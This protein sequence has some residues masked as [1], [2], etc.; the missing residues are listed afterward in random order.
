V[1][2][3]G[4]AACG[5][6]RSSSRTAASAPANAGLN[7]TVEVVQYL[8]DEQLVYLELGGTE[9]VAKLSVEKTLD[10]GSTHTFVV[11]LKKLHVFDA[12]TR[13][14]LGTAA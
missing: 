14:S 1:Y 6:G 11:P 12:E 3:T 7:A 8:G 10:L 9:I 5:G 13:V 2:H 4:T